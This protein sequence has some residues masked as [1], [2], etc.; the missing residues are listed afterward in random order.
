M[1]CRLCCCGFSLLPKGTASCFTPALP[2]LAPLSVT[3]M[4]LLEYLKMSSKEKR[5]KGVTKEKKT[6]GNDKIR[7]KESK[8]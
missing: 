7:K 5:L 3:M 2:F 8:R 6:N 1:R 4:D